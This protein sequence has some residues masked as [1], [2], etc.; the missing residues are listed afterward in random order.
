MTKRSERFTPNDIDQLT[1]GSR[2]VARSIRSQLNAPQDGKFI[3]R[4]IGRG[5][6]AC[7]GKW[8]T[9]IRSYLNGALTE[10]IV[11]T[12]KNGDITVT[13]TVLQPSSK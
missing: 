3:A 10:S 13:A 7:G 8:I 2:K 4:G 12:T 1:A 9:T 5:T 6:D 11:H